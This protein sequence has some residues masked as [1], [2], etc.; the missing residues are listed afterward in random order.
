MA[1]TRH[2]L[3]GTRLLLLGAAAGC[4]ARDQP[5]SA[6]LAS[7]EQAF[8]SSPSGECTLSSR[9]GRSYWVCSD[10]LTWSEA[11][12]RCTG[13]GAELV[14][15]DDHGE[16]QFVLTRHGAKAHWLG[17]SDAAGEGS[18]RW[19]QGGEV[20]WGGGAHGRSTR[21]MF[22]AWKSGEPNQRG[23]A[24]CATGDGHGRWRSEECERT[25]GYVCELPTPSAAA[26]DS[27]CVGRQRGGHNY[28]F[29]DTRRDPATALANCERVGM[30]LASVDDGAENAYIAKQARGD[31]LIGL[32][33]ASEPGV[34][35]WSADGRPGWCGDA[36]GRTPVKS[37]YSNW[38]QHEPSSSACRI[39]RH[40]DA[41][42]YSCD[43]DKDWASASAACQAREMTLAR[44]DGPG[45][46]AFLTASLSGSTWLGAS[47][48]AR[49][50]DWRWLLGDAPISFAN[51]RAGEPK[52]R[53]ADMDCLALERGRAGQWAASVCSEQR[54]WLCESAGGTTPKAP[55]H[56]AVMLRAHTGTWSSVESTRAVGYVC[57][58][59]PAD[60]GRALDELADVI[61]ED[62]RLGKPRVG[63]VALRST[64][65]IS[66]PFSA[67]GERLGM[68]DCTDA[69]EKIDTPRVIGASNLEAVDYRQTYLG[70][71]VYTRGYTVIRAADTKSV[72]SFTGRA[73]PG[74]ALD[75][76]PAIS[77]SQARRRALEAAGDR[78]KSP[79]SRG[80]HAPSSHPRLP[81]RSGA[82]EGTLI[83]YPARQGADPLWELAWLFRVPA[84]GDHP[85]FGVV[86]SARSGEVLSQDD[87]VRQQCAAV[88]VSSNAPTGALDLSISDYQQ[89][90]FGDSDLARAASI[91]TTSNP[92]P[93]L[94]YTEGIDERI[95]RAL[96]SA[97][98]IYASC[99]G[100]SHPNVAALPTSTISV[101]PLSPSEADRGASFFMAAQRC[102][103][104]F[105][106]DFEFSDGVAWVGLDGEG[107][108]D[109]DIRLH[110]VSSGRGAAFFDS[111][112]FTFHFAW[113][114]EPAFGA[115]I[116]AVCHE[117][118]HAVWHASRGTSAELQDFE[119][120]TVNEGIA[121]IMGS[122]TEMFER[123]YPGQGGFCF[124]G[125]PFLNTECIHD[126]AQPENSTEG[127]C[128]VVDGGGDPIY[129]HCPREFGSPDYCVLTDECTSADWAGANSGSIN[130][131]TV[132]RNS[133]VLG[134]W[135]HMLTNGAQGTN[136][137]SCP[138]KVDPLDANLET[139]VRKAAQVVF[140]AVTQQWNAPVTGFDGIANAT[141][142]SV[143]DR[144]GVDSAELRSVAA[145][146]FAANVRENFFEGENPSVQPA[147]EA[148]NVYPWARF[149]W[150]IGEGD[151]AWDLQIAS[152]AEF[153]TIL[154]QR[155][156]ITTTIEQDGETLGTALLSLPYD[157][158]VR[159]FWR[160]RPSAAV[161]WQDCYPIHSFVG[162]DTPDPVENIRVTS[163]LTDDEEV[164]PGPVTIEWDP[165][166]GAS[167]YRVHIST[168]D[169]D[170]EGDGELST[171]TPSVQ[172]HR[173][174]PDEHYFI[175]VQAVGP[176][177]FDNEFSVNGCFKAEFDT[178]GLRAPE[179]GAPPDGGGFK[180]SH[181]RA[182]T[183]WFWSGF[184][185]PSQYRVQFYE[186]DADEAC[187]DRVIESATVDG[188]SFCSQIDI[189]ACPN[190]L[191][192]E[193]FSEPDPRGYCWDVT[194]IA[195]NG[196]ESPP[197]DQQRF[198]YFIRNYG[199][200]RYIAPGTQIALAANDRVPAPLPGNSYDTPVTFQ[201]QAEP[202][203]HSYFLKVGRWPW[204]T[205]LATPDPERC[206]GLNDEFG[207]PDLPDS[208]DK[209]PLEPIY[210]AEL[211]ASDVTE[212]DVV[213][214]PVEGVNASRGR[215]CWQFWPVLANPD[216]PDRAW[217]KQPMIDPYPQYCYTSGPATPEITLDNPPAPGGFS[218]AQITGVIKFPYVPDGQYEF[219]AESSDPDFEAH[220]HW[221]SACPISEHALFFRDIYDCQ[222]TFTIDP[223][224]GQTYTIIARTWNSAAFPEPVLDAESALPEVTHTFSTGSCGGGTEPCC[225]GSVCDDTSAHVCGSGG[226]CVECGGAGQDCCA[227]NACDNPAAQTCSGA[228]CIDCGGSG[229]DCC[230]GGACDDSFLSCRSGNKCG[231]PSPTV[232][233]ISPGAR[234]SVDDALDGEFRVPGPGARDVNLVGNFP[235]D[236]DYLVELQI[237]QYTAAVRCEPF[238]DIIWEPVR[239]DIGSA[240]VVLPTQ[241][242]FLYGY[243]ARATNRCDERGD[244]SDYFWIQTCGGDPFCGTADVVCP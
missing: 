140:D 175:N 25:L 108:R 119:T 6:D 2:A 153:S 67:Y 43:A 168:E 81:P 35:K 172:V 77:E 217:E 200:I 85:A 205:A 10:E 42:Y 218:S 232:T 220:L 221:G 173:I 240:P 125:D 49:E 106:R 20:F 242:N 66:D 117:V 15:I 128:R 55:D 1:F 238:R 62:F 110:P 239:E 207:E 194:A 79:G 214:V 155:D 126:L 83:I 99:S 59:P 104:Y 219:D 34:W 71:P 133:T 241:P 113:D 225:A 202:D 147:R 204:Q 54:D 11:Q 48:Q 222:V 13:V 187:T 121:D 144:Y 161:G 68:R 72:K 158:D 23:S 114:R 188:Q 50:G 124:L 228:K 86:I 178:T 235:E 146:W 17:A 27:S 31:A 233:S 231:C 141:L 26:P 36:K 197:S 40:G 47:D 107:A 100:Q 4:S 223:V 182:E 87:G 69:F 143:R 181:D 209:G 135:F 103:D 151:A 203:A 90:T 138:F 185:Q 18:W 30:S 190:T 39:L 74:I 145:A 164:R 216:D 115:S 116:E 176:G 5:T 177:D 41:T 105:A 24:R 130:C 38:A 211:S 166:E 61:R 97:P 32:N 14:R 189:E 139:S 132:H 162:T 226:T 9:N 137:K 171:S 73:E 12:S 234:G 237:L 51:W 230:S 215:Y 65:S 94:L 96:S 84:A 64:A 149:T 206:F 98:K 195:A 3:I 37:V 131:C 56:R 111:S 224:E 193:V 33:D 152:D 196:V 123:G 80:S 44:V 184:D 109:I 7:N 16:N 167:F 76:R 95:G 101:N 53:L 213:S 88:D 199:L 93:Y 236:G 19:L 191:K 183:Q 170:C 148:S 82:P 165:V 112:N 169:A 70:I 198:V 174:Q 92:N 180:Y 136:T 122:A 127:G 142:T 150:P 159:Y 57:E 52:G 163:R 157:T 212:D 179:L 201:W 243:R 8:A 208:C 160:T 63:D 28:W 58:T 45:E 21:G 89:S 102:V 134:H 129:E 46:N 78:R 75:I 227:G 118:M 244:W 192:E 229:Q 29:C 91:G 186:L 156:R 210:R 22:S 154:Y 60:A 120:R